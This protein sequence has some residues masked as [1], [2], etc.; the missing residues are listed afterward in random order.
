MSQNRT[1]AD[2][3]GAVQGLSDA[4]DPHGDPEVGALVAERLAARREP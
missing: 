1:E 3:A 4:G 2:A